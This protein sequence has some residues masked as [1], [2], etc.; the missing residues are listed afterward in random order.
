MASLGGSGD[1]ADPKLKIGD[2]VDHSR[3][4]HAAGMRLNYYNRDEPPCSFE[5][6]HI[7]NGSVSADPYKQYYDV[8]R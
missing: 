7:Q 4:Q 5:F 2:G 6:E 3:Q 1:A 8:T